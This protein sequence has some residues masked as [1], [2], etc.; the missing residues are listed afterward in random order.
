MSAPVRT[1]KDSYKWV[2]LAAV[3]V[4]QMLAVGS[5]SFGFGLFVKP[6]AAEFDVSRSAVNMGLMLHVVGMAIA[7]PFIGRCLDCLPARWIMLSGALLFGLGSV[8]VAYAQALWVVAATM[9]LPIAFGT[10]ALGPL[11]GS[12]LVARW[13]DGNSGRALG[14][15]AIS[16]SVGGM[17]VVPTMAYLIDL[18]GWRRAVE[19]TGL[20]I[21][22]LVAVVALAAVRERA[23]SGVRLEKVAANHSDAWTIPTLLRTRDFWLLVIAVGLLLAT[24]Q[25]LLSALVAYGT[26]RG[27]SSAEAA[28]LVTAVSASS[29]MG[30]MLIG[31]LADLID[32][33]LL[34]AV[35]AILAEAF[36]ALLLWSPS[37]PVLLAGCLAAGAAIGGTSPVWA[38]L[39]SSRFGVVSFGTVMGLMVPLQMPLLLGGI[40]LRAYSYDR[41]GSYDEAF[42]I[43]LGLGLAALLSA[44]AIGRPSYKKL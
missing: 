1:M 16:M 33:R 10:A 29:I 17:I 4:A 11:T 7:S 40:Y 28:A 30:K 38:S 20:A 19:I 41:T 13:F 27:F 42:V 26:D 22:A 31:Y 3:F 43:Y 44:L 35:V 36:L 32:K 6:V 15:A 25:G 14:I 18:W 34:L 12:T 24:S 39:I 23:A 21:A 9:F 37:Y 2:I 5:T 8:V